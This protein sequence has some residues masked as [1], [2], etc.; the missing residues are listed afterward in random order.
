MTLVCL[1]IM[2]MRWFKF[3]S[4]FDF[5]Y[6]RTGDKERILN[7]K[8]AIYARNFQFHANMWLVTSHDMRADD[9]SSVVTG[10]SCSPWWCPISTL[11]HKSSSTAPSTARW[12]WPRR[13]SSQSADRKGDCYRVTSWLFTLRDENWK[14]VQQILSV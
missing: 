7:K 12:P 9:Q 4:V 11:W 6:V 1:L 10:P 3:C 14:C 2:I 8:D 5:N 13:G